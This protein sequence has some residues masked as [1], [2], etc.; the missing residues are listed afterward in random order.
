MAVARSRGG[1]EGGAGDAG[2][3]AVG[4]LRGGVAESNGRRVGEEG[5]GEEEGEGGGGSTCAVDTVPR[6]LFVDP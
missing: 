1:E 5:E 4:V 3:G 2:G 6:C